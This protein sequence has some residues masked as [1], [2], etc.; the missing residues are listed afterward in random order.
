VKD[1][2]KFKHRIPQDIV[3]ICKIF[4]DNK[5]KGYLV[6]GCL[7]DL[8]L[9]RR[10]HDWDLATDAHPQEVLSLF[11]KAYPTG[12][13][14]GTITIIHRKNP[15]EVTTLRGNGEYKNG[16]RPEKVIFINDIQK[17]LARRDFTINALAYDPI[18]EELFDPFEG[19]KDLSN[20]VI[21]T[22]GDPMKRFLE[23]GLRSLRAA[24]L[25]AVLSFKIER[26]TKEAMAK[27]I[28]TFKKIAKERIR[29]ELLKMMEASKPSL[30][31]EI[32]RE[33]GLLK[34]IIPELLKGVKVVQNKFHKYDVYQHAL[35]CCDKAKGDPI[36]K[37]I[38]L[39]HDIGKPQ[40]KEIKE[41][42]I[43]FYRHESIGA[44][45]FDSWLKRYRF[46]TK[47]R[48]RA[49]KLVKYHMF[50]YNEEWKPQAIRRFIRKVGKEHIEEI[51]NLRII[52][53]EAQGK[54]RSAKKIME[55]FKRSVDSILAQDMAMSVKDLAINGHDIMNLLNIPP[56]PQ[57]GKILK[58]L[59]EKVTEDPKLNT[60]QALTQMIKK[61]ELKH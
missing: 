22:V 29:D 25:S 21:R 30:G 8:I 19:F 26:K 27:T 9:E 56:S 39:F 16:R 42:K 49:K 34:E 10:V 54:G 51:I 58:E 37:L 52:D 15:Y 5:R 28:S 31:L 1:L 18:S 40:T 41:G 48:E 55:Q 23:D 11:P 46:P 35:V 38:A 43:T 6:G 47:V 13:A 20:K 57:I 12:I 36:F 61:M 44:E 17:D 60:Y 2:L 14:H 32:L 45:I 59:L 3:E 53:V 50:N 33:V 4:K 24:R 7:R